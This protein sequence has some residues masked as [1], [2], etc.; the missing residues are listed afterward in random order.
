MERTATNANGVPELNKER[1]ALLAKH[2]I[3][4][5]AIEPMGARVE[6]VDLKTE[7]PPEEVL[8]AL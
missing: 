5:T 3:T 7:S 4:M 2:G 8:K 1:V 6:G